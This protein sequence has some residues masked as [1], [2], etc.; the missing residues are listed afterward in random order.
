MNTSRVAVDE[1]AARRR[2]AAF[3]PL[4]NTGEDAPACV[5]VGAPP[6]PFGGLIPP[7]L[8]PD[9]ACPPGDSAYTS[10]PALAAGTVGAPRN[11]PHTASP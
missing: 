2:A 1:A 5:G 4:G 7:T 9:A 10:C 3:P 11:P 8:A 6:D